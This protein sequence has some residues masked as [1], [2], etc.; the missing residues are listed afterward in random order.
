MTQFVPRS[1]HSLSVIMSRREIL[2]ISHRL[3]QQTTIIV[4]GVRS[5]RDT[6][7]TCGQNREIF[8]VE[9]GGT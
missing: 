9:P 2:I 3:Q 8:N 5:T 6:N 7:T 1:K 4:F